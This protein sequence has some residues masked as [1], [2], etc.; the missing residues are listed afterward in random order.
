MKKL[1]SE[2]TEAKKGHLTEGKAQES[3]SHQAY[4]HK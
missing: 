4:S 3:E 2:L 1:P